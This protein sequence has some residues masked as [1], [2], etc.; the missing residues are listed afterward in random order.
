MD[1]LAFY[2]CLSVDW[3]IWRR[4]EWQP[5]WL[6]WICLFG[7]QVILNGALS[8]IWNPLSTAF[9]DYEAFNTLSDRV[10]LFFWYW[11]DLDSCEFFAIP[12]I[13]LALGVGIFQRRNWLVRGCAA[14]LVYVTAITLISPQPVRFTS[15][16]DVRYAS[17]IIPLAVALE[18]G[19]LC[20][21]FE[22]R[23]LLLLGAALLVFGTNLLNGGPFLDRGLRSTLLSYAGELLH[24]PPDPCHGQQAQQQ[25]KEILQT[26]RRLPRDRLILQKTQRTEPDDVLALLP[27][28]MEPKRRPEGE[29]PEPKPWIKETGHVGSLSEQFSLR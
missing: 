8:L 10:M 17:L 13:L 7:P 16:A 5:G 20:V 12:V 29:E 23:T 25:K 19:V 1:Y 28:Q 21:L 18:A 9:G 2:L 11:R 26:Q 27:P 3:L 4:R 24:P 14:L 6:G 15:V 22:R